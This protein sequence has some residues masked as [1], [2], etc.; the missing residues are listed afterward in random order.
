M[1]RLA[2]LACV[3]SL[4]AGL[5]A[6]ADG[7]WTWNGPNGGTAEGT[8]SCAGNG[9]GGYACSGQSTYVG[10]NGRQARTDWTSTGTASEGQRTGTTTGPNG[11][12]RTRSFTW[13][14][15]N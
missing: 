12:T 10:P 13:Q 6:V 15:D 9:S 14:R 4:G 2:T 7:Q 8:R 11:Q 1:I 5:P 3:I